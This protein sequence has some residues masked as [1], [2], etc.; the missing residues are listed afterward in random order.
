[1]RIYHNTRNIEYR[2]P[3]GALEVKDTAMLS[4]DVWDMECSV[5]CRIWIDGEGESIL[6]MGETV[7][8]GRRRFSVTIKRENPC[9]IWYSFVIKGT[10]EYGNERTWYLGAAEGAVSGEGVVY[11]HEPP[12]FQITVYRERKVPSW[13]KEGI[14]YQI[15]PDRFARGSDWKELF[16]KN[17]SAHPNGPVRRIEEDW[18]KIP[19]YEKNE[20]GRVIA[21][22]FY[23]GTLSGITEKLDY[24]KD[25]GITVLYLN[26]VFEAASNHRYDTGDYMRIDPLLGGDEAFAELISEADKRGIS[27]ILDGVFNHTGCD[28]I[29]FNKYGNYDS[30]GA[31]GN[32][33][34]PYRNWY[35]FNDT[36][37]GYECWWGVDDLPNVNEEDPSYQEFIYKGEDSVIARYLKAGVK[38]F[39]LDVADELPD[40]FIA[41]IKE[42]L[43]N[44][45]PDGVLIGEVWED[46]SNKI[47][48]GKLRKY[49]QGYELD[50][51]MNYP[52]LDTV[53]GFLRYEI[54]A[55]QA[56]GNLLS[57]KENYPPEALYSCLNLMGSHDRPRIMTLMGG[58]PAEK[59]VPVNERRTLRLDDSQKGIAKGRIWLMSLLQMTLPGVPC[60]YYGDEAGMEGYA[61]PYNRGAYP[62]GNEDPDLMTIYRN[63]ITLR[64]MFP[65]FI[66]G[67]FEPFA[68]NDD[69]LGH[70]RRLEDSAVTVLVNRSRSESY[71]VRVPAYGKYAFEVVGGQ[72]L[73]REGDEVIIRLWPFGSAVIAFGNE[74]GCGRRPD[75][76]CG[77]LCHLTSLPEDGIRDF[78]DFLHD[79]NMK[80]WQILPLNPT[81]E[82]GS[83]YA[84]TSAFA[85]NTDLLSKS[86]DE[87]KADEKKCLEDSASYELFEQ[88]IRDNDNWLL[89]YAA[90]RALKKR[91]DG[92]LWKDWPDK[93]RTYSPG[94]IDDEEIK[95]DAHFFMYCQY[96]FEK[97]WKEIKEYANEKGVLIIGDMPMYVSYDSADVWAAPDLFTI[98][99][100]G[101]CSEVAGVPPD[102]FAEEGQ[103]WGNPL[104]RWDRMKED[105]Y[106]WW[107][108]RLA[109]MFG[110]YDIT[111]LDHFRGFESFWSVP[112]GKKAKEGKWLYGPG[113]DLFKKAYE[114]LGQLPVIAEDLGSITPGVRSLLYQTGFP[115]T[116]VLQFSDS[117]PMTGY[118]PV[119]GKIAYT[120]THDNE[121]LY[122]WCEKRYPDEEPAAAWKK[123]MNNFYASDADVKIVPIQDLI[124][125]GNEARMNVPGKAE[126]NWSFKVPEGY[127]NCVDLE[128]LG[129]PDVPGIK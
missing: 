78:I 68:V 56:C 19:E 101:S 128:G 11:D 57:L 77:V 25:L 15:F 98:D 76:G 86:E 30:C 71:E 95:E 32:E 54:T 53:H 75:P 37:A 58:A 5:L 122:G 62:W 10:D 81:D 80:Y 12:S 69:V 17:I 64:R 43:V 123:L 22:D 47:S 6:P 114:K 23:G 70:T 59:D 110:L 52:L 49:L 92:A 39:R 21:W 109:R 82:Y 66:K 117:D 29:Y 45:R 41:G 63:T 35:V 102:Y 129:F 28:S 79:S 36:E 105:G 33:D 118:R 14:V 91:F 108:R 7:S 46:A 90:F 96:A 124:G 72:E 99:D 31:Y 9:I 50:A 113:T 42:T 115:G 16:E 4:V 125:L 104:Y 51:P 83:P 93:Y 87:L 65:E 120:G 127:K 1:M 40:E 38:G 126:G 13:Y 89:P 44:T 88:F 111:R 121:T 3:F 106:T 107:I 60:I 119:P 26:P 112:A 8:E 73:K 20:A 34:S 48:Y 18:D 85:G 116:D 103:L 94:L 97:W 100:T 61:D 74:E 27:V 24:L 67:G 2:Y 55:R 84:G